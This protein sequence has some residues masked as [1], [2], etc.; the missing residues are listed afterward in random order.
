MCVCALFSSSSAIKV[1]KVQ[2][3]LLLEMGR[4]VGRQTGSPLLLLGNNGG[5]TPHE[6]VDK[7]G[8]ET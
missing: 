2:E 1:E 4:W 8:K 7:L 6:E 5:G 3:H